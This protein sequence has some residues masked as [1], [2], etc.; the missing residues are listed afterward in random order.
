VMFILLKH[1]VATM[2]LNTAGANQQWV[3][4]HRRMQMKTDESVPQVRLG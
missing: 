1:D 2:L 4:F 3:A